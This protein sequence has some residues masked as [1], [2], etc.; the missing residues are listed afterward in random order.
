MADCRLIEEQIAIDSM[1]NTPVLEVMISK[2]TR[3]VRGPQTD[4][5]SNAVEVL[6]VRCSLRTG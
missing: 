4:A 1:L 5:F 6:L 2:D 3:T